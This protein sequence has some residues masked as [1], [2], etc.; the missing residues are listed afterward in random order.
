M[1]RLIAWVELSG[2]SHAVLRV[3]WHRRA[4][5]KEA[6]VELRD[7]HGEEHTCLVG[8]IVVVE[9]LYHKKGLLLGLLGREHEHKCLIT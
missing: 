4:L 3:G 9:V 1:L 2:P 7:G 6:I 8:E 5:L